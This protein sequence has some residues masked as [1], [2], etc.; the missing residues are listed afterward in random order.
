MSDVM[1]LEPKVVKAILNNTPKSEFFTVT[2]QK[3][4]GSTRS[5]TCRRG[6]KKHLKGGES[7]ISHKPNLISVFDTAKGEYRCFNITRVIS[8]H[9][10]GAT[11]AVSS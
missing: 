6:V 8:I 1:F 7:T 4:D 10:H 3:S 9:T 5:M 11:Y 2:F